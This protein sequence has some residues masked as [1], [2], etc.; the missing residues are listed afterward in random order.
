M[1]RT[2]IN[3]EEMFMK[4]LVCL[5]YVVRLSTVTIGTYNGKVC[6]A[7]AWAMRLINAGAYPRFYTIKCLGVLF[8]LDGMLVHHRIPP[9]LLLVPNITPRWRETSRVTCLA[10]GH[11]RT[12]G[13]SAKYQTLGPPTPE[14]RTLSTAPSLSQLTMRYLVWVCWIMYSKVTC[15]QPYWMVSLSYR[16]GHKNVPIL[17][18]ISHFDRIKIL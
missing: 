10:H 6:W 7:I 4:I 9:Q 18:L 5:V 15:T 1:C 2:G 14:S 11:R 8:P 13:D 17:F 12:N 16:V 3:K